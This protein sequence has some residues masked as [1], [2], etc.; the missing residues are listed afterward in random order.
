MTT[1]TKNV[2]GEAT[3]LGSY[4]SRTDPALGDLTRP[5]VA[6]K[7]RAAEKDG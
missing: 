3:T 5:L 1:Q 4:T 7:E 6:A 2:V